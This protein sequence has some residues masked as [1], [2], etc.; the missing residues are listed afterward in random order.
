MTFE[1]LDEFHNAAEWMKTITL[2]TALANFNAPLHP[3]AL[4]FYRE[5]GVE[6]PDA[7]IPPEAR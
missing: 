3:G 1:H 4:R 6:I 7:L 2:Q 5:Q